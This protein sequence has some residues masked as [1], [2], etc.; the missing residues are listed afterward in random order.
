MSENKDLTLLRPFNLEEA[1]QGK[2]L[3]DQYNSNVWEYVAGPDS[4]GDILVVTINTNKFAQPTPSG[5]FKMEPL[6]WLEARPVYW[7]SELYLEDGTR[8]IAAHSNAISAINADGSQCVRLNK[9]FWSPPNKALC[10]VEGKPVKEN[11]RLW[12]LAH[13]RYFTVSK[14]GNDLSG[15]PVICGTNYSQVS[16]ELCR[17]VGTRMRSG[18]INIYPYSNSK[19]I[20]ATSGVYRSRKE[21][22][23]NADKSRLHCLFISWSEEIKDE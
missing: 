17:W 19:V 4:A 23:N 7:D 5:V 13:M 21:A 1:K 2:L 10:V 15:Q 14:M 9:L 6:F 20:S 22:D 16:P 8:F 11:D 12:S 3:T 18:F